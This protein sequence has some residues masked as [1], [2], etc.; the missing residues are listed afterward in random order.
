MSNCDSKDFTE[1]LTLISK[2]LDVV[3]DQNQIAYVNGGAVAD[4]IY[5]IHFMKD[6]CS[7]HKKMLF[8]YHLIP[9]KS[10]TRL[11]SPT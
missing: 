7:L 3:I 1:A 11:V 2:V 10:L 9:E 6:H 5:S 4:N 8:W